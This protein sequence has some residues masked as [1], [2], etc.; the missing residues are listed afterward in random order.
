[1]HTSSVWVSD[2]LEL[3][4]KAGTE[5]AT[6]IFAGIVTGSA[7]MSARGPRAAALAGVIGGVASCAYW[8]GSSYVYN[9]VLGKGGKF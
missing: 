1:M 8:Y 5:L 9:V 7:Y 4:D 2:Q 6:P 3:D